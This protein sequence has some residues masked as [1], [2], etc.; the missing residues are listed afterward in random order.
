MMSG[1]K[2]LKIRALDVTNNH[3]GTFSVELPFEPWPNEMV[4]V[5]RRFFPNTFEKA[6]ESLERCVDVEAFIFALD[7][8]E[9]KDKIK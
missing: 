8:A 1:T 9:K 2:L 5:I 7:Y 4:D 6:F 3:D